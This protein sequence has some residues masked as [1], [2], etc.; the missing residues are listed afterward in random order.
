MTEL[1]M[2]KI[3]YNNLMQTGQPITNNSL[4]QAES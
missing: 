2:L 4:I 3:T 1:D